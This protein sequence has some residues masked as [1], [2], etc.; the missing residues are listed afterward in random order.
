MTGSLCP[1]LPRLGLSRKE[2]AEPPGFSCLRHPSPWVDSDTSI[3]FINTNTLGRSPGTANWMGVHGSQGMCLSPPAPSPV[4]AAGSSGTGGG[5]PGGGAGGPKEI[6]SGQPLL[7]GCAALCPVNRTCPRISGLQPLTVQDLGQGPSPVLASVSPS[8][9]GAM[10][11]AKQPGLDRKAGGWL[12]G[13]ELM[14]CPALWA[15]LLL[16]NHLMLFV[17][18]LDLLASLK[19]LLGFR[20]SPNSPGRVF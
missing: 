8:V 4:P 3:W 11:H 6:T 16:L 13:H 18:W 7:P 9:N 17:S 1:A 12:R 2:A 10:S 20:F 5:W 15:L 19:S 14:P